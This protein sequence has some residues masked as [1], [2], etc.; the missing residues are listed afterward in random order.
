MQAAK[1]KLNEAMI[2]ER[3]NVAIGF[4]HDFVD[5]YVYAEAFT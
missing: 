1:A 3:D 5:T 2:T 4:I